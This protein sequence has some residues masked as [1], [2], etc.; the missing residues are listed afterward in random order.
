[1]RKNTLVKGLMIAVAGIVF[2][3]TGAIPV[4][5]SEVE[6]PQEAEQV[7]TESQ[8]PEKKEEAPKVKETEKETEQETEEVTEAT[9]EKKTEADLESKPEE[10]VIELSD[11]VI[12]IKAPEAG[13]VT[14]GTNNCPQ[15]S[16][17]DGAKVNRTGWYTDDNGDGKPDTVYKGTLEGGTRYYAVINLTPADGY[18][19][20]EETKISVKGAD[21]LPCM[22]EAK[23]DGSIEVDTAVTIA[24][25]EETN[26]EA[27]TVVKK[28]TE[29]EKKTTAKT[30]TKKATKKT[31]DKETKAAKKKAEDKKKAEAKKKEKAE[32]KKDGAAKKE[33]TRNIPKTGDHTNVVMLITMILLS[34][35][36]MAGAAITILMGKE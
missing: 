2:T 23:E 34:I 14:D 9:T 24:A 25:K 28:E 4:Y 11:A 27:K 21:D 12:T 22:T 10:T 36:G 30:E 6:A 5:A 17:T 8:V 15:A 3:G 20:T 35:A 29:A 32:T 26:T 13:T 18:K 16:V 1:M 31:S 33:D 7:Q 19:L